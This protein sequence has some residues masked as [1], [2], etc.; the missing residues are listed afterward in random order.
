MDLLS[1]NIGF[2]ILS[3]NGQSTALHI[4]WETPACI[5]TQMFSES[6]LDLKILRF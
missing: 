5:A 1:V 3:Y 6:G 4:L 2:L